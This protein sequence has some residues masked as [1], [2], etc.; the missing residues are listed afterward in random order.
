MLLEAN[1]FLLRSGTGLEEL[2]ILPEASQLQNIPENHQGENGKGLVVTEG[3]TLLFPS[4]LLST[5]HS[6]AA[7]QFQTRY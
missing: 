7:L 4:E 2:S 5:T 6:P 1:P 3:K